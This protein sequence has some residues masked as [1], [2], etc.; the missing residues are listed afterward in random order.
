MM[1]LSFCLGEKIAEDFIAEIQTLNVVTFYMTHL[2]KDAS[3]L[4]LRSFTLQ[5]SHLGNTTRV[6]SITK[7]TEVLESITKPDYIINFFKGRINKLRR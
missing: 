1:I 2:V 3:K 6:K 7:K 4:Q 5:L